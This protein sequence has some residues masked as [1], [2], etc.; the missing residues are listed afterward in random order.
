MKKRIFVC[1]LLIACMLLTFGCG[2]GNEIASGGNG[3]NESSGGNAESSSAGSSG[4]FEWGEKE[5]FTELLEYKDD[6]VSLKLPA[7]HE[8]NLFMDMGVNCMVT[9][10]RYNADVVA[11]HEYDNEA[12]IQQKTVNGRTYDYQEIINYWGMPDW[13]IY[14]IRIAFT[15]SRNQME[16]RYYK[17]LYT[18]Y[19]EDYPESQVEKFMQTIVFG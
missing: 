8:G 4:S 13:C 14:V 15:E 5:E 2:S 19:G 16:H 17:I 6:G 11:Y 18:V 1:I 12:P 10:D 7:N 3:G 9:V